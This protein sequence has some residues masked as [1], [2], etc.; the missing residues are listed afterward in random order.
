MFRQRAQQK[1]RF[2]RR[3]RDGFTVVELLVVIAIIAVLVAMLIPSLRNAREQARRLVCLTQ[4][5]QVHVL[6]SYYTTDYKNYLPPGNSAGTGSVVINLPNSWGDAKRW[7]CDSFDQKFATSVPGWTSSN[8]FF[9]NPKSILWCPSGRRLTRTNT[10][11]DAGNTVWNNYT[12]NSWL[13]SIDYYLAGNSWYPGSGLGPTFAVRAGQAWE[14]RP[15]GLRVYSMDIAF[16]GP[17]MTPALGA[18]TTTNQ[19][20]IQNWSDFTPHSAMGVAE[21]INVVTTDGAGRWVPV[22]R[23]TSAGGNA[24]DGRWQYMNWNPAVMPID[25]EVLYAQDNWTGAT[26]AS[27][28]NGRPGAVYSGGLVGIAK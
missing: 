8:G 20:I 4:Q 10:S 11:T 18:M 5:R 27:V 26:V 28:L 1:L 15:K 19:L 3:E 12:Q 6:A 16:M 17:G 21:G 23:C 2:S 13:V 22:N 7:W 25:Y 9:S 24:G 14:Y